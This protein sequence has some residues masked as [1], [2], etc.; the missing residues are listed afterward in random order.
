VTDAATAVSITLPWPPTVNH[1]WNTIVIPKR[2]PVTLL[3]KKG[4]QYR[5]AVLAACLAQRAPQGLRDALD[6]AIVAYPPD[7]RARDLDNLL[8][9]PLDGLTHANVWGNDVDI[10]KLSI[11]RGDTR[12]GAGCIHITIKTHHRIPQ[13]L[14]LPLAPKPEPSETPF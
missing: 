10:W 2:G 5:E 11:E 3:S 14:E 7:N 1:M 4:R 8:K 6:V 9:A 12:K 13:A